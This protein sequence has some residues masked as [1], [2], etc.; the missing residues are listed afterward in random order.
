[1]PGVAMVFRGGQASIIPDGSKSPK[2]FQAWPV[3]RGVDVQASR[4]SGNYIYNYNYYEIYNIGKDSDKEHAQG[5]F[6]TLY[7]RSRILDLSARLA[8]ILAVRAA[9]SSSRFSTDLDRLLATIRGQINA[10]RASSL[11]AT[12]TRGSET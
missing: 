6:L 7:R 1:M 9:G 10:L 5:E 3:M 11:G 8:R 4:E 2:Q 12:S